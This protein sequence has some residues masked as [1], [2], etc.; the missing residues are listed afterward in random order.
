MYEEYPVTSCD[1]RELRD[2]ICRP[3]MPAD[4]SSIEFSTDGKVGD[5]SEAV[6][7]VATALFAIGRAID[8]LAAA[9]H[10]IAQ[11]QEDRPR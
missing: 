10:R 11:V 7:A 5:L 8:D 6:C 9:Q 2:A 3:C 4:L 1:I